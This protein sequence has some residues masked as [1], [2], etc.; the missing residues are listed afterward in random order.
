MIV[1]SGVIANCPNATQIPLWYIA[2]NKAESS[3]VFRA[4]SPSPKTMHTYFAAWIRSRTERLNLSCVNEKG[5]N[6]RIVMVHAAI[7]GSI[8]RF[9]ALMIEHYAG[10]FPLWLSPVQ[11]RIVPISETF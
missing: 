3:P 11:A 2:M 5:E 10:H 6:E 9:M 8:E 7:M 4:Y 1:K